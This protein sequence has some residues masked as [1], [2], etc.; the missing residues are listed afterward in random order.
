MSPFPQPRTLLAL[1]ARRNFG[2]ACWVTHAVSGCAV[3]SVATTRLVL[4]WMQNNTWRVLSQIVSTAKK[5]Q[6]TIPRPEL[7]G[8]APRS[9]QAA[10]APDPGH[11][12]ATAP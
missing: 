5:S 11:G 1:T 2:L 3:T 8:T 6:A 7:E 4:S 9:A 10:V 12:V